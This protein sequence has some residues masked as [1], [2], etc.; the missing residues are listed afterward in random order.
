MSDLYRIELSDGRKLLADRSNTV[1]KRFVTGLID[2]LE[3]SVGNDVIA[4]FATQEMLDA[5]IIDCWPT[6]GNEDT[7]PTEGDINLAMWH[8]AT[9]IDQ[10]CEHDLW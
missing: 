8:F 3:V 5:M 6:I 4:A 7:A 1:I 2:R 9:V 10:V